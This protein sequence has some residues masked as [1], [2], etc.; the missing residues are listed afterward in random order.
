M[1]DD[2]QRKRRVRGGTC[3]SRARLTTRWPSPVANDPPTTRQLPAGKEADYGTLSSSTL[4][5]ALTFQGFAASWS[6][7][8]KTVT[9]SAW[10]RAETDTLPHRPPVSTHADQT[11]PS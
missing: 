6:C 11:T 1:L 8:R 9:R 3:V 4:S 10:A 2:P 7:S 5:N